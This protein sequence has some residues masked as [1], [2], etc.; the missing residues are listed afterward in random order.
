MIKQRHWPGTSKWN[1]IEH[2][3]FSAITTNW[4]GTPLTSHEAIVSLIGATRT[5]SGPTVEA[6]LDIGSYP[7]GIKI[8]NK[9]M[10]ALPLTRHQ[11]HS[12]WN[13][14]L[15]PPADTPELADVESR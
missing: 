7:T 2:R 8:S 13:Y 1:R 14:T 10:K 4:R 3:L 5:E 15:N 6:A 12:Q 9:A 11:T